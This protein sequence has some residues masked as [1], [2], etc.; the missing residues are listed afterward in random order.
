[1]LKNILKYFSR[2]F[3]KMFYANDYTISILLS[4]FRLNSG[5]FLWFMLRFQPTQNGCRPG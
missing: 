4:S 5:D 1:M 2:L 3:L